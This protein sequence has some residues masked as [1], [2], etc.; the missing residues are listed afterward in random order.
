[1]AKYCP[2]KDGY[3]LYLDCLEC[4]DKECE[5]DNKVGCHL[6]PKGDKQFQENNKDLSIGKCDN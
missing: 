6:S 5:N 4:D 2:V 3:V 1:M